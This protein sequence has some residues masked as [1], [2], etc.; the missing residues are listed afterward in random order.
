ME[1]VKIVALLGAAVFACASVAASSSLAA[2]ASSNTKTLLNWPTAVP[3]KAT[4][5]GSVPGWPKFVAMGAVAGPNISPPTLTS[6]G[7]E[8]DFGGRPIDVA[9]KYAGNAGTGD[10]GIID[11]PTNA[12]RMSDDW[13]TLS[14]LNK[15]ATRVA[16]VEYTA[17]L[18]GGFSIADFTNTKKADPASG[19]NYIMARHFISLATD[20]IALDNHP[21]IYNKNKHYG[22][23]IMNPDLMGDIEQNSDIDNVNATLPTNAVNTAVDEALCFLTT[24]RSYLN[25]SNPNGL[26]APPYLDKTYNGTPMSILQQML[27]DGYPVWSIDAASDAYWNTAIDNKIGGSGKTYAQI[28]VWFNACVKD[29]K[30]NKTAFAHPSFAAGFEGW[31]EANNWLIRTFSGPQHVTFGWQDNLWAVTSSWWVHQDLTNAEVASTYSTPVSDWIN[32]NAP[33]AIRTGALGAKYTPSY[34]VFDRFENDDSAGAGSGTL[35]N[36]RAWDNY[37]T[38]VGQVSSKNNNIPIM[39]WQIPGSHIPYVGEK[40]PETI[41]TGEYVFSTAPAYFFGE[42]NLKA[43]LKN[44]VMGSGD[45]ADTAVGAYAMDCSS[46]HYNCAT[47]SDYKQFLLTYKGKPNNYNWAKANAKLVGAAVKAHVFAILWGGGGTTS[48]IHNFAN[49]DD[50]GWLANKIIKYYQHPVLIPND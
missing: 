3:A 30:Y 27:A 23:L 32:T 14:P 9:F 18:S 33:S 42:G 48:V 10:P 39:M 22:T 50:H 5:K 26:S 12:L 17:Q 21:V 4:T 49:N 37:L 44:I 11:A 16:M 45:T 1:R 25:T 8:D 47:N 6:T 7:G 40:N 13:N 20:A 15:H 41:G 35:Y 36:A 28:G 34:F 19:G 29:P 43:D 2:G 38:A 31:V 24:K 46:Q